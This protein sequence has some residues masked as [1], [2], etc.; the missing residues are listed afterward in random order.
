VA[1]AEEGGISLSDIW[2]IDYEDVVLVITLPH[3]PRE[4]HPNGRCHWAKKARMTKKLRGDV[5]TLAKSVTVTPFKQPVIDVLWYRKS[6]G[7]IDRD[8]IIASLKAVCDGLTDARYW[9]DDAD[10]RW[11]EVEH[12]VDK[13]HPRVEL[14]IRERNSA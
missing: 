1:V 14:R 2:K 7:R 8:G 11:G 3:P 9:R 12:G 6:K 13:E 10:L 4:L 5:A